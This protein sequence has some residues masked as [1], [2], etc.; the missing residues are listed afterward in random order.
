MTRI[1]IGCPEWKPG[2]DFLSMEGPLPVG[3]VSK[4]ARAMAKCN[5]CNAKNV[6]LPGDCRDPESPTPS[7]PEMDWRTGPDVGLSSLVIWSVMVGRHP[8]DVLRGHT[9]SDCVPRDAN[10]FGRCVRLL[11]RFPLWRARL[12]EIAAKI[13]EW[14]GLC[15]EWERLTEMW[16]AKSDGF[17]AALKA[18]SSI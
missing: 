1:D 7:S 4:V 15:R 18:A 5:R 3:I 13:P 17:L 8:A 9:L 12:P 6:F 16:T 14:D 11:L 2:H 10:D